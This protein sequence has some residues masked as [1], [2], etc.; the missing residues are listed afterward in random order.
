[1]LYGGP[2]IIP[3]DN[4]YNFTVWTTTI[5]TMA[6]YWGVGLMFVLL[7]VTNKPKFFRKYKTQPEAHVPLDV[8]KFL[9]ASSRCLFNQTIVGI[10]FTITFYYIGKLVEI[11]ALE[12]THSFHKVITDL[13]LMGILYEFGFYYSHRLLH[14][15]AIYKHIHKV[16]H[17]WTA[18]VA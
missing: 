2:L 16:H 7:D 8:S 18:P 12:T 6:L 3:A 10:P 13:F 11:P 1:V 15:R 14:H 9:V 17:E 5:Y 4:D